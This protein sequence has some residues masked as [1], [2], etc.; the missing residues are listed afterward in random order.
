MPQTIVSV[1]NTLPAPGACKF[2]GLAPAQLGQDLRNW[3]QLPVG[4]SRNISGGV[5]P[6]SAC[7]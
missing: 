3:N 7:Q 6:T 4:A 5:A 2:E 1:P